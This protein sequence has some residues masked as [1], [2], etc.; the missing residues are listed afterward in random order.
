[1]WNCSS[2]Y[3]PTCV[4]SVYLWSLSVSLVGG[5]VYWCCCCL[6]YF[7]GAV[8]SSSQIIFTPCPKAEFHKWVLGDNFSSLRL[9]DVYCWKLA[10]HK[11]WTKAASIP[12]VWFVQ[13]S[14]CSCSVC[15]YWSASKDNSI[16]TG[17][18]PLT[19]LLK[20][21]LLPLKKDI[22]T[23]LCVKWITVIHPNKLLSVSLQNM[24]ICSLQSWI[25]QF[26]SFK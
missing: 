1:M 6:D 8:L 23:K 18:I 19:F 14:E 15:F 16:K 22:S 24:I 10:Y 13:W 12:H 25:V 4:I 26:A 9:Q 21:V 3:S 17:Y 7:S 20:W 5:E 2:F 11:T